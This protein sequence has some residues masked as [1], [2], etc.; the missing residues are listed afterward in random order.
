M[1]CGARGQR[2]PEKEHK[3][4]GWGEA[5]VDGREDGMG[6]GATVQDG[7]GGVDNSGYRPC[8]HHGATWG[9]YVRNLLN[10]LRKILKRKKEICS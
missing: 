6:H 9:S 7:R 1:Q 3:E 4:G 8:G 2:E 10:L 5:V